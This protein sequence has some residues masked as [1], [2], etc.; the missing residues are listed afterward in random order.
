[1]T[2]TLA[3]ALPREMVRVRDRVIPAYESCGPCSMFAVLAMRQ[4]LDEAARAN[5]NGDVVAMLHSLHA[6][7]A[8]K[9]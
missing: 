3:D 6:L 1:M 2:D 5:M 7:R 4:E 9:L 8:F